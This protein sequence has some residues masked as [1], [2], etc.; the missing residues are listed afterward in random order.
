LVVWWESSVDGWMGFAYTVAMDL[1]VW[2]VSSLGDSLGREL[3]RALF[4]TVYA[5]RECVIDR[6]GT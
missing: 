6:M 2:G 4:K 1:F 5:V 3:L